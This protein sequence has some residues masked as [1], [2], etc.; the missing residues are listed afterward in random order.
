MAKDS[1]G[2]GAPHAGEA[3]R[4]GDELLSANWNPVVDLLAWSCGKTLDDVRR[5]CENHMT[6]TDI[7]T[8]LCRFYTLGS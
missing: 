4:Y 3:S 8:F 5:N 6:E 1:D 2:K 7:D